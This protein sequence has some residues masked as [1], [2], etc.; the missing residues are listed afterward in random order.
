MG[1]IKNPILPEAG[2]GFCKRTVQL[3]GEISPV[4]DFG[5]FGFATLALAGFFVVTALARI[6]ESAFAIQFL[7]QATER[8]VHRLTFFQ[9]YFGHIHSPHDLWYLKVSPLKGG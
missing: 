8:L 5:F 7:F 3:Q 6:T 2:P 1:A 9:F 4:V